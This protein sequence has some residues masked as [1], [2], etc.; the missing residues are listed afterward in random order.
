MK[1]SNV[2]NIAAALLV[3]LGIVLLGHLEQ[4]PINSQYND[5]RASQYKI[6]QFMG[7]INRNIATDSL[8][9]VEIDV[10]FGGVKLDLTK[11]NL[12]GTAFIDYNAFCGGTEIIIPKNWTV[13]DDGS[14]IFG[15]IE[16]AK[17]DSIDPK[18]VLI[19]NG[20]VIFGGVEVRRKK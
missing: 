1:K 5:G 14:A 19:I 18:K 3:V 8:R 13:I 10:A 9:K 4:K 15:G 7:G 17:S 2:Y 16:V 12:N 20:Q 11:V 6:T